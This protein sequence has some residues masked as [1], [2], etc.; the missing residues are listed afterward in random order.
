MTQEQFLN[1][2]RRA[3]VGVP[4][5]DIEDIVA[6]YQSYF[7]E[8]LSAGRNIDD[9]VAA[10]GDPRRLARE[11]RAEL[12]LRHWEDR[13]SPG[14]FWN[15]L[16]A[17]GGLAAIDLFVLIPGLIILG[18]TVLILFFVLSLFGVI[19]IGTLLDLVSAG[20]DPAEGTWT[21]LLFRSIGFLAASLGGVVLLILALGSGMKGLTRYVRLHYR[22]LRPGTLGVRPAS[23]GNPDANDFMGDDH[24]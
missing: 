12:G 7:A 4:A 9:V 22:L 3:L 19:G 18:F 1:E 24:K 17:L 13:H 14:S 20:H 16:L 11:L 23:G 15:A 5:P 8:A 21:Y 2:L 10:H 6:D